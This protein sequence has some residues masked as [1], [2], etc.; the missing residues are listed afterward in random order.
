MKTNGP[1]RYD[2]ECTEL[3]E[4]LKARGVVLIVHGGVKGDGFEVHLDPVALAAFP[5]VLRDMANQIE[6]QMLGNPPA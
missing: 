5:S 2:P 6:A 3:R 4:R 1:G